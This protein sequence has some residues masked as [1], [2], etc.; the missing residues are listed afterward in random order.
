M[1]KSPK[2]TQ[3]TKKDHM[4][5]I[6]SICVSEKL[7]LR[8]VIEILI[9]TGRQIVLV[10]DQGK[11]IGSFTDGDL[12]RAVLAGAT[13]EVPIKE[14]YNKSAI[15][16]KASEGRFG[17]VAI[18]RERGIDQIPLV[19]EECRVVGLE[20]INPVRLGVKNNYPVI[21]MAGGRGKR[22]H[23][24][25]ESIPKAL[26]PVGD[27]PIL[28][29]IIERLSVQGFNNIIISINHMGEMIRDYF[30]D[31]SRWN[32]SIRYVEETRPL[33]T[34]GAIA[35]IDPPPSTPFIV[36][37]CDILTSTNFQDLLEFHLKEGAELTAGV[38]EFSYQ[39]PYGVLDVSGTSLKGISEKPLHS[40]PVNAGIYVLNPST[41]KHIPNNE[42]YNMT[43]LLE[44]LVKKNEAVS[45]YM[46]RKYWIDIG[47]LED[48]EEARRTHPSI[49]E[50]D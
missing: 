29:H 17:A 27:R 18:M 21:V 43:D 16:A 11:L 9:E 13:L 20:S 30:G 50:D 5:N 4:L 25:T 26:V 36:T 39:I 49:I 22:L 31:G 23:P 10:V 38:R 24:I 3:P 34:A 12:R 33:G 40:W 44:K 1:S 2:N 14:F 37:N 8:E 45:A 47:Q 35:L 42:F 32:I 6:E 46:V 19:D 28:E 48:L 15:S 7:S 41:I